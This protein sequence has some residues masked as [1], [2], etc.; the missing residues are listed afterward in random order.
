MYILNYYLI[1]IFIVKN[2]ETFER[3]EKLIFIFMFKGCVTYIKPNKEKLRDIFFL[4]FL[5][6]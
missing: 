6:T 1:N 2:G 3:W 5:I 4:T